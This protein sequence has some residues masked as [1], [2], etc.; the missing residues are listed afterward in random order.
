MNRIEK[1]RCYTYGAVIGM[2][3][4]Y[5]YRVDSHVWYIPLGIAILM[6]V[7]VAIDLIYD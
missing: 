5:A 3:F 1:F 7:S 2:L 6:I 4:E